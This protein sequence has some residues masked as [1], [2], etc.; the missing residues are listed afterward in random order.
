MVFSTRRGYFFFAEGLTRQGRRGGRACRGGNPTRR[1][2][3]RRI[4]EEAGSPDEEAIAEKGVEAKNRARR[5]ENHHRNSRRGGV[6]TQ[7][8]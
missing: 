4:P 5:G 1:P 3:T 7:D 2:P 6:V 8:Y